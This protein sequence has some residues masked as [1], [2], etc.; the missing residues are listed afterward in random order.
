[1]HT[2]AHTL[3]HAETANVSIC[4]SLSFLKKKKIQGRA[5]FKYEH[6]SNKL[7]KWDSRTKIM[8]VLKVTSVIFG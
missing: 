7:Y 2:C 1:M 5:D 4:S 8:P 6:T 3:V